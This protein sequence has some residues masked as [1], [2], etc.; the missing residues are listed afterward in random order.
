M[1]ATLV[2]HAFARD[3]WLFERKLD[4][5]RCLALKQGTDVRLFSRNQKPL[6]GTYPELVEALAAQDSQS[7]AVDGEVVAFEGRQTSFSR[8]QRRMQITD[9]RQARL[10]GVPVFYYAFDLL[11]LDGY[12][13]TGLPLR[14]RKSLLR[15]ALRWGAPLRHLPH[16]NTIGDLLYADA[17]HWG[18]EG[19]MGKRAESPYVSGRSRD[20]LKFKCLTR[21]AFVVVGYTDPGGGRQGFGA[22][23]L[24]ER[25]GDALVYVGRVGTGFDE[26]ALL[27]IAA[28][29]APLATA[30]SPLSEGG[31]AVAA[32]RSRWSQGSARGV[33]WVDPVFLA[34]VAFSEW[35]GDGHLRHPRFLGLRPAGAVPPVG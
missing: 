15:Q 27:R 6:N 21:Q 13:T 23:V 35:T 3:G 30:D 14:E 10:S 24:A 4:G 25:R 33:H 7:F 34:D 19:V 16:R 9:P 18:W 1:L 11:H 12:D 17:C 31:A 2:D 20:W 26:A 32:G 28:Q 8:L 29:L 22:L 5:E